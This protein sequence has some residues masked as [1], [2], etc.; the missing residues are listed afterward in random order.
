MRI[1]GTSAAALLA[2]LAAHSRADLHQDIDASAAAVTPQVIQ[3]RRDIH[4][5]PELSNRETRTAA[6]VAAQLKSLGLDVKTRVAHTGVVAILNGGKPGK[7][8]ALRADMDALPVVEETGLP[9]ASTVKST[10]LGQEVGVMHACGHD[11][12][13]AILLGVATVLSKVR[14]QL[15]GTVKFIFQPA[16]EGAPAGERGGAQLMVEEG[17]LDNPRVDAIFGLHVMQLDQTGQV[18]VRALGAMAG[19]QRF[20]IVVTG[21]QTH[22][23]MPWAGID[24][25]V[26]ASQIVTALQTIVSRR[27]DL[28]SSPAV[29]T[30]G[31]F[32]SGVRNNIVPAD[33]TLMGTIR[34][35]DPNVSDAVRAEMQDIV[36]GIANSM[37]ASATLKFGEGNPPTINDPA[38]LDAMRPS[39]VRV[40]GEANVLNANPT[41]AAEDFAFYQQHVPGR[42]RTAVVPE[43]ATHGVRLSVASAR[44]D[45]PG[46]CA[47]AAQR[48]RCAAMPSEQA[49]LSRVGFRERRAF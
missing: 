14:E 8:V 42:H 10:Y 31:S 48:L 36:T 34:T 23:A 29:V 38:L 43:R 6:L 20:E 19:S 27:V 18:A 2:L 1:V 25:I 22:G 32:H 49:M 16:E 33:A 45:R 11:N 15:P 5:H 35:F 17:V 24:P 21:K 4:Q 41:M 39:L 26:V 12:H 7:V 47:V 9:Y 40:Y 13:T 3:W 30:V 44:T 37:G 46:G 28:T